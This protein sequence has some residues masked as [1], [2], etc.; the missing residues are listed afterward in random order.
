MASRINFDKRK[1]FFVMLD[2]VIDGKCERIVVAYKDR[3]S[4]VGFGLFRHLF[5]RF[6]CEIAVMSEVG[7]KKL[8]SEETVSLLHCY[9]MKL[10]S[11]RKI[12]KIRE[13]ISDGAD[14]PDSY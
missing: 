11:K 1:D 12:P 6:N 2:K 8:D 5:E 7:S 10:Y 14:E 13:V 4:R 9:S 3:L